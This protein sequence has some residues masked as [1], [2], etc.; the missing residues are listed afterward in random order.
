MG[1]VLA[2]DSPDEIENEIPRPLL[3]ACFAAL[4]KAW[5]AAGGRA[6]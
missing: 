2:Q 5:D 3:I 6:G 1:C 4:L